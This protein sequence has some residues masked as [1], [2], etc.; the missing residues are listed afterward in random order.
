MT[1]KQMQA[2]RERHAQSLTTGA[3]WLG[4]SRRQFADYLAGTYPIPR[5]VA[6]LCAAYDKLFVSAKA[7]RAVPDSRGNPGTD[8]RPHMEK[9]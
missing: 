9:K 1:A 4:I 2:W 8:L 6:L 3:E 5:T 7:R